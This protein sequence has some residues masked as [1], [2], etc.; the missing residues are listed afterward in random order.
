MGVLKKKRKIPWCS[1]PC[2]VLKFNVDGATRV[3]PGLAGIRGTLRI[4]KGKVLY[5]FSKH[6]GFK[7]SNEAEVQAIL[8]ALRLYHS[9]YQLYLIVESDSTNAIYWVK[10]LSGPWKM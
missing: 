8:E 1:P 6:V 7:E 5:M 9:S 3:K 2:G 10:S 4:H